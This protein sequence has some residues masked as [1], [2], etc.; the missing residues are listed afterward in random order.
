MTLR[1]QVLEIALALPPEDQAYVV[2]QLEQR[3]S[4]S[5]FASPEVAAAW[6]EEIDRRISAF[7]RGEIQAK[8]ANVVLRRMREHLADHRAR[9]ATS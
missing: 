6:G 5:A 3:L 2:D 9:K 4:A 8:D 1:E 7:Q